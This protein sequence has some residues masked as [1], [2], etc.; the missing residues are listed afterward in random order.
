MSNNVYVDRSLEFKTGAAIKANVKGNLSTER[1]CSVDWFDHKAIDT[2]NEYT[3]AAGSAVSGGGVSGLTLTTSATDNVVYYFATPLI[4]DITQSP[5]IETKLHLVDVS[6][7]FVYF[8]FSNAVSETSP[9]ATID[10]DSGTLTNAATDAAG[11]VIDADLGSSSIWCASV[12]TQS[13]GGT[14]QSVDT[15]LDWADTISYVLRV[16]LDTSGNARFYVDGVQKGYI[17]LAV[18]DV[19]LCAIINFGTR[20]ADGANVVYARYLKKWADVA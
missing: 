12:K 6:G 1:M 8:G 4:F 19:P 11:F 2:T 9:A 5:V 10:A 18:A 16:A 17:A 15:T 20:A 7:T 13:A 14:V 3:G